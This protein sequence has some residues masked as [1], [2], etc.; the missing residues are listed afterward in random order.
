MRFRR[1]VLGGL[2]CILLGLL[3]GIRPGRVEAAGQKGKPPSNKCNHLTAAVAFRD[4]TTDGIRSDGLLLY[5]PAEYGSASAYHGWEDSTACLMM[6]DDYD[7]IMGTTG[8]SF[9]MTGVD[10]RITLNFAANGNPP[11]P[12]E[13]VQPVEVLIRSDY[14]YNLDDSGPVNRR[15]LVWF[16]ASQVDYKLYF[17]DGDGTDMVQ[18]TRTGT[19]AQKNRIWTI[20]SSG[21]GR[22][23]GPR[24]VGIVGYYFMPFKITIYETTQPNTCF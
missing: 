4:L 16:T 11:V 20:E 17:D 21:K 14:V 9:E 10:R 12:F 19:A 24:K 8:T 22:L 7:F 1:I 23:E 18:V 3:W 5:D 15:L 6:F 2:L 13:L